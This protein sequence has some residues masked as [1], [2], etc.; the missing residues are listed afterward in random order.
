MDDFQSK[1]GISR[2]ELNTVSVPHIML[3][4]VVAVAMVLIVLRPNWILVQKQALHARSVSFIRL[5]LT[6]VVVLVITHCYPAIEL[7]VRS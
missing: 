5:F 6:V 1:F 2:H 4:Q 3:C 7:A